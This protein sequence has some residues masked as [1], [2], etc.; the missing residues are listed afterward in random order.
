MTVRG[1]SVGSGRLFI[2]EAGQ[3]A[4]PHFSRSVQIRSDSGMSR[5]PGANLQH[6][7]EINV[8][9]QPGTVVTLDV[10]GIKGEFV[11]MQS[12]RD[13]RFLTF[14]ITGEGLEDRLIEESSVTLL[15]PSSTIS[16][17]GEYRSSSVCLNNVSGRL[18]VA[19]KQLA[20]IP[21]DTWIAQ[22]DTPGRLSII[23]QQVAVK[24]D[25]ATEVG[26][27][28]GS[29]V[30]E[31]FEGEADH[32]RSGLEMR[33]LVQGVVGFLFSALLLSPLISLLLPRRLSG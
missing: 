1:T 19:G 32:L 11:P 18:D 23:N 10:G 33:P 29:C 7:V 6:T 27:A 20:A 17:S 26:S 28:R 21:A 13:E 14:L 30:T 22:A 12:D 31:N 16:F 3:Q 8:Q 5:T 15:Y 4:G 2:A 24:F 9:N 25:K